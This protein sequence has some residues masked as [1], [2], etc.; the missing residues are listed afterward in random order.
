MRTFPKKSLKNILLFGAGKSATCLIEYLTNGD[1][2]NLTVC[3]ADIELARSKIGSATNAEA[4]SIDVKHD[5]DRAG[6][7]SSADIVISM[8]PPTLHFLV[9]KDCVQFGKHLLTASYIDDDIRSLAPEIEKKGLFFLCEMGLDPGIDHMSALNLIHKI[10]NEGGNI[11][12]FKSHCGGLVAPQ[13]DDNPWH[14]KI[15]WNPRN[16]V[17]A[18]KDGAVYRR[19]KVERSIPYNSVFKDCPEINIPNLYPLCWYP[20]RNS[21]SYI[22][23]YDLHDVNTFIRTT[24]RHPAF[25]KGWYEL[26][27]I[28]L[29]DT[30]DHE[31]IK[32]CKTF[33]D[34]FR[35]KTKPFP[36]ETEFQQQISFLGIESDHS[37]PHA[38]DSSADILQ[39]LLETKLKMQDHDKDLIVMLHEIEYV[40]NGEK[41]NISSSLIVTGE[42]NRRTAMAKTVGLP[43]GITIKLMLQRRLKLTGLH[44]PVLLE[45][46]DLVLPE[47]EKNGICFKEI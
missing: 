8:L 19:D 16:I 23:L 28:G 39:H 3:D 45:I 11:T 1:H 33:A 34:W 25:C 43:L 10:K 4:V 44:I 24:L 35:V 38:F 27:N 12:S 15:S 32:N 7:I 5:E 18:G 40:L 41:K 30:S 22:D 37:L 17:L 31:K 46:Y 2:L 20:N 42:D 9:A 13:S 14:Y 36:Y 26:V 29:T 6:L 21:L 47:L